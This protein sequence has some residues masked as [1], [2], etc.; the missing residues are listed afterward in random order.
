MVKVYGVDV[1]ACLMLLNGGYHLLS[2]LRVWAAR[3]SGGLSGTYA[4]CDE[5]GSLRWQLFGEVKKSVLDF[6]KGQ[7]IILIL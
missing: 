2:L 4:G 1:I 3:T 5:W 6:Q 7:R